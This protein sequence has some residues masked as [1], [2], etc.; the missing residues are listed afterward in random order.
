MSYI[1]RLSDL[2][3][4]NKRDLLILTTV[5]LLYQIFI[6]GK[7]LG[8]FC[9]LT[10]ILILALV[11]FYSLSPKLLI[12]I[13]LLFILITFIGEIS[14]VRSIAS[15]SAVWAYLFLLSGVIMLFVR[16]LSSNDDGIDK[17]HKM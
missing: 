17:D 2:L 14:A 10:F 12:I 16:G 7:Y 5:S 6:N 15:N 9:L 1:N 8:L 13:G 3:S 11:K 4:S